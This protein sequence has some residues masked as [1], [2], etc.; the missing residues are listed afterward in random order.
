M[1]EPSEPR[2]SDYVAA[3]I[4]LHVSPRR[5][6]FVE[7]KVRPVLMEVLDV[8]ANHATNLPFVDGDD[9]VETLTPKAPDPSFDVAVLP[10][11]P[12]CGPFRLKTDA[13]HAV[14][15]VGSIDRVVVA[16]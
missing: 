14:L 10:W 3:G 2:E 11:G 6:V 15:E 4:G 7:T 8:R 9:V 5:G 1:M 13:V 12:S 16:D